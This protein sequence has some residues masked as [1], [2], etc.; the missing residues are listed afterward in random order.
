MNDIKE[1]LENLELASPKTKKG[2]VDYSMY[3]STTDSPSFLNFKSLNSFSPGVTKQTQEDVLDSLLLA[4]RA[5]TKKYPEDNQVYDWYKMY[6]TVLQRIGWLVNQKDF[7]TVEQ[8]SSKFELDKAIFSLLQ[9]LVTGQQIKILMRSIELLKSLGE[10]DK[11]LLAFETNTHAHERGNFQLGMAE[12]KNGHVTVLGS[13]FILQSQKKI[14]K[15]LF[16]KFDKNM[17]SM[18]FN[19]FSADLVLAEYDKNRQFIKD[20]LGD[21]SH[22][23]ASLDL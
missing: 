4:Q 20:K 7:S 18:K 6:F 13:G 10:D 16:L 12:T 14:S 19:F 1:Y 22:F 9:D 8:K 17:I 23:I 21:S 2:F 11:R 3:E 15:I 5:A